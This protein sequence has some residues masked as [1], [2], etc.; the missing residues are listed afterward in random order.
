MIKTSYSTLPKLFPAGFWWKKNKKK[1][2]NNIWG[3][4]VKIRFT[5]S[6]AFANTKSQYW[7][8]ASLPFLHR[9]KQHFKPRPFSHFHSE[10][11]TPCSTSRKKTN[12]P[13]GRKL[14]NS[15]FD[16][17]TFLHMSGLKSLESSMDSGIPCSLQ[18]TVN[19][20]ARRRRGLQCASSY[21]RAPSFSLSPSFPLSLPTEWTTDSSLIF[22]VPAGTDRQL[23]EVTDDANFQQ[24][25]F[26][27]Q[28]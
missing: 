8:S 19:H 20:A 24:M 2:L 6:K 7:S 10:K 14:P 13:A 4:R 15:S 27:P 9:L 18:I 26:W 25:P 21:F 5:N 16:S 28:R 12:N 3:C 1:S 23:A 11:R 22:Q 17:I